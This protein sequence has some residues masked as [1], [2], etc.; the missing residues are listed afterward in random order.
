MNKSGKKSDFQSIL[1][2]ILIVAMVI[3]AGPVTAVRVNVTTDQPVYTRDDT[4]ATFTVSV[5]IQKDELVPVKSL[6]LIIID[7][8][9]D[10]IKECVFTPAG[11]NSCSNM[12]IALLNPG[13]LGIGD[14][15][16]KGFGF[17]DPDDKIKK[18]DIDFGYGYGYDF[19]K[20]KQGLKGE[21]LY[22]IEWDLV[23]DDVQNGRYTA[24]MEV[25]AED[26]VTNFTYVDR[27]PKSFNVKLQP[28]PLKLGT[29]KAIVESD[30]GS[31]I[32]INTLSDF[33][34]EKID[35]NADL[36]NTVTELEEKLTGSTSLTVYGEKDDSTKVTMKLILT[37]YHG[38][39]FTKEKIQFKAYAAIDYHETKVGIWS[40]GAWFGSA[41]SKSFKDE[42][43]DVMVTIEDGK[44]NVESS[45]TTMPFDVEMFV[46]KFSFK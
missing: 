30:D 37:N 14:R 36:K 18:Q 16:A 25:Y 13:V 11:S 4:I 21:L 41:P 17:E 22:R 39:E 5:D 27:S 6:K 34:K 23:A 33:S 10:S 8:L 46:N 2:T 3:L 1:I 12:D 35:F 32:F 31:I 26:T 45:D 40:A 24:H 38:M 19:E 7:D 28:T 42:L 9:D 29:E 20:R 15:E 43:Q 44:I